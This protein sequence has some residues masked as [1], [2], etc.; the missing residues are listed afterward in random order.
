[1]NM[2][3]GVVVG[4]HRVWTRALYDAPMLSAYRVV[5]ATD[6]RGAIAGMILA[7][8]GAE[9]VLAEPLGGSPQRAHGDGLEWWAY[10]RGKQSVVCPTDDDVL[11][12][13]RTADV[14]LDSGGRFDPA[15]VDA[16]NPAVVHVTISAFGRGGPKA[17]WA[18]SDLTI[19]A[20][21]CAQALNGDRDRA[22]VRTAVPQ[23]W[24]HAGAEAAVGALLALTE[25]RSSG[26]GQHVDIS[27][28]QAVMQAGIP[29]VLLAPNDNAE[30]QRT[31]GGIL[32]GPLHLQ[33]VYPAA[34]GYV[35]ITL[36]FGSMIGPYTRR[37]MAW[38]CEEGHCAEAMRDWDF[39]A[40]GLRMMTTEEGPGELEQIKAAITAMTIRFTKAELFA[41]AQ[42][43]RILLAPVATAAELVSDEHL[44]DR[45]Y[46][47]D[48]DGRTC[49]GPFVRTSAWQ[50]PVL[51]APPALGVNS[52]ASRSAPA[53]AAAADADRELPLAGLKVIDLTWVYAGPLAT[54]VLADFGA[55]VVKIEGPAHPDASR[56]GGGVINGDFGL[57]GSVAFAHFNCGK[58][59]LGLD[60]RTEAGRE[61]LRDLVRWADVLVESFTPGVMRGWG[62]DFESLRQVNPRL[63]MV[64]TSLMGQSGPLSEFAGFG[65]LAGAITGFYELTGWP[66]RAPAGPFLAYTDYVA[67]RYLLASLLAALDWRETTGCGQ[68][69][70]L[71]QAE[72]SIHFLGPAILDHTVN[73]AHPT[74]MGNAD[75]VHHPHGV[76][77]C[78]GDDE[79]VAIACETE[80]QR[81]ALTGVVGG[82]TDEVLAAWTAE[83]AVGEVET[84]LQAVGV[85]V[86]GVQNSAA[87]WHDPQLVHRDHYLTVAHPVHGSC[88]VE[89]SRI[90]LSRTPAVVRRANPSIGEHN[91]HVLR[92]LLDYDDDRVSELVIA[93]A[94]G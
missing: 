43:R 44:S 12:L 59:G 33:F 6:H 51:P 17:G 24:L 40:F 62:L 60:L 16:I 53:P 56:G 32:A 29:G 25:R 31:S 45:E 42:R 21:G 75:R 27:A 76:Y 49:P 66:D 87:C 83:R 74:R 67:P 38:V 91:D 78:A 69:I 39:D 48:V 73:G 52:L 7:G 65:N 84:A 90:V 19:L 10:N 72:A 46:W 94:L 41:E 85:P 55:T 1:M 68:H 15:V 92:D 2:T 81:V 13:V 18:A 28:Q 23:A 58:L 86:H 4:T 63:V 93:G 20:A 61:V 14:L 34:D 26:R 70:D 79:W 8:L 3:G 22:P 37:L 88:I 71:S 64:S 57:E 9:V 89:G 80:E 30:A 77:P 5:D 82:L 36:L 35:S 11:D 50:V 47:V 54:R